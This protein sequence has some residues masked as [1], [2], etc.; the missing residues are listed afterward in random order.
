MGMDACTF[1][2]TPLHPLPLP[3]RTHTH[4]HTH[5]SMMFF[6]FL[7]LLLLSVTAEELF[8]APGFPQDP[9]DPA[10]HVMPRALGLLTR[11]R[12]LQTLELELLQPRSARLLEAQLVRAL[13]N[14]R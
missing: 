14:C 2:P 12:N 7:L 10:T 5:L 1:P 13:P 11:L 9:R 4:T 3:P 6:F 8:G